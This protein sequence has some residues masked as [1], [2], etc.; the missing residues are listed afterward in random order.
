M[1]CSTCAKCISCPSLNKSRDVANRLEYSNGGLLRQPFTE[2]ATGERAG[3][4]V[5]A[6][7]VKQL[8]A[9][10][11]DNKEEKQQAFGRLYETFDQESPQDTARAQAIVEAYD[12]AFNDYNAFVE[13]KNQRIQKMH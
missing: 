7:H 13:T 2:T 9:P 3:P 5:V 12:E 4:L 6:H 11:R 10:Y 8:A 1:I